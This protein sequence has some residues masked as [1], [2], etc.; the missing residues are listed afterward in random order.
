MLPTL[1]VYSIFIRFSGSESHGA[2][3]EKVSHLC[4]ATLQGV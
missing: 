2:F 4:E 1:Q 3:D